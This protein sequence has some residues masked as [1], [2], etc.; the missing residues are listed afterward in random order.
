MAAYVLYLSPVLL[1]CPRARRKEQDIYDY[2]TGLCLDDI[3]KA[4]AS[5]P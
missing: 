2:P 5:Y 1:L 3:L 4:M